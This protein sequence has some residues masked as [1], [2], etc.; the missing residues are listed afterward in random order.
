MVTEENLTCA[1]ARRREA[2]MCEKRDP[3]LRN[4]WS[5]RIF[6]PL[7]NS[8][9]QARGPAVLRF[10]ATGEHTEEA[11][12]VK[13]LPEMSIALWVM[14]LAITIW[15]HV[16]ITQQPPIYD[17][18]GYYWKA[19][20]FWHAV[21]LG[22]IFNPLN[23]EPTFRPPGTVVMAYPFGFD[24]DP[25]GLY[26]R[27]V[28]FPATLLILAVL[29]AASGQCHQTKDR[30]YLA[31]TAI[32]FSTPS[33]FYWFAVIPNAPTTSYWGLVDG[34]LSGIAALAA[35]AAWRSVIQ[36]SLTW[37][38]VAAF[39]SSFCI[40]IKPSGTLVAALIGVI[41][42]FLVLVQYRATTDSNSA[43]RATSR[44]RL[45]AGALIIGT[46]DVGVLTAAINSK[47]LSEANIAYGRAA[48]AVMKVELK[49]PLSSLCELGRQGLGDP[50]ILWMLLTIATVAIGCFS[51]RKRRDALGETVLYGAASI[52]AIFAVLFGVWFWLIGSGGG[53]VIRYGI[54]F[55]I[56]AMVLMVPAVIQFRAASPSLLTGATLVVMF[57]GSANLALLLI[58][59]NPGSA[60]QRWSGVSLSPGLP[61]G[62]MAQFQRFVDTPRT[63]PPI[64]YSFD[65][66]EADEILW[67]L[68]SKRWI[69]H[70]EF[71]PISILHPLDWK[72]P[73][74]YRIDELLSSDYL[75]FRPV[76]DPPEDVM[77][78]ANIAL[79]SF[80]R[81]RSLFVAWASG[82]T[83][84]DGVDIIVDSP[85]ARIVAIRDKMLLRKS[86]VR[87]LLGHHWRRTFTDA[88][89]GALP[90][91]GANP[92][93]GRSADH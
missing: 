36:K 25:R 73:T 63:K 18:F 40:V 66:D 46:M 60:W 19:Y 49:V 43:E 16:R 47:Y 13:R 6:R 64:V 11:R 14:F 10:T 30:W 83:H 31:L 38:A 4:S 56:I 50:L 22:H 59:P 39:L 21:G 28:F 9:A 74:T 75:L 41:W 89:R 79:D 68:C 85:S 7:Q 45:I 54:P 77:A 42:L 5:W 90:E 88:N 58:H 27:S 87:M 17:A 82:L 1:I 23:L 2:E 48:I 91:L 84:S 72:R 62:P 15:T 81:E 33:L 70:P 71:A 32:F 86:L 67:S 57:V 61:F 12:D 37:T 78:L 69:F 53:T 93:V 35:A 20:S 34:F 8:I 29:V 65:I 24:P 92:A 44:I 76:T 26:F 52:A 3:S 51:A 80:N 55:F